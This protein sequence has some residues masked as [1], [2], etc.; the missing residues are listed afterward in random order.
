M[1]DMRTGMAKHT[2][3]AAFTIGALM[4]YAMVVELL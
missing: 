2:K 1:L 4:L 3:A